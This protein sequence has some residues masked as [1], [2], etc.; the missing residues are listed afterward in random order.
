M[1]EILTGPMFSG[2]TE[3]LI[4]RVHRL[5][6]ALPAC[7]IAAYKPEGDTRS[8]D[9]QTHYGTS[10]PCMPLSTLNGLDH[11]EGDWV[12]IDE[13][14]FQPLEWVEV[15]LRMSNDGINVI[16]AGL[17]LDSRGKPFNATTMLLP[18]ADKISLL[19]AVCKKCG[20]E[21]TKTQR[22]EDGGDTVMVGGS[23]LYEA[24]CTSCWEPR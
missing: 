22:L 15:I 6:H 19:T 18:Y 10:I 2:K 14:Q 20:G 12:I 5:E 21:A 13:F 3:E 17:V 11:E 23:D 8:E 1:L 4:R 7:C 24:R 16:V 9:I